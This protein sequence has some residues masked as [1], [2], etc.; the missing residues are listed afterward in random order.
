MVGIVSDCDGAVRSRGKSQPKAFVERQDLARC[1]RAICRLQDKSD[2]KVS[3]E[4]VNMT[5]WVTPIARNL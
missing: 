3:N 2:E 5:A 4:T 1:A